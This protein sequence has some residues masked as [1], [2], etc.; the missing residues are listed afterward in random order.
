LMEFKLLTL[1]LVAPLAKLPVPSYREEVNMFR[2]KTSQAV[3][4]TLSNQTFTGTVSRQD[5]HPVCVFFFC[6]ASFVD[7][8]QR[9]GDSALSL[10]PRVSQNKFQRVSR[11]NATVQG[12]QKFL[13]TP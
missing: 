6:N 11:E 7:I 9:E 12:Y 8:A 4:T 10:H 13:M 1:L 5:F 3:D 2:L